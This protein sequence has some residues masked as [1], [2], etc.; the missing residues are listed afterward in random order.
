[1]TDAESP[2]A[3]FNSWSQQLALPRTSRNNA[4]FDHIYRADH[5]TVSG[6]FNPLERTPFEIISETGE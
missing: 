3:V 5:Q 4:I 6:K 1:M 2:A